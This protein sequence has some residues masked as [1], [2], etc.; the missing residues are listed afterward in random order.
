MIRSISRFGLK[1]HY[2]STSC[3]KFEARV[4]RSYAHAP[5]TFNWEDPL[6]STD[7]FTEDELA[8]QETAKAYCQERMLPRVLGSCLL[9]VSSFN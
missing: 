5:A 4:I 6:A 3:P 9:L 8:I 2:K 1:S 7:L